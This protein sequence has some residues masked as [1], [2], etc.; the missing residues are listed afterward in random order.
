MLV[1]LSVRR[2]VGAVV[3]LRTGGMRSDSVGTRY[4]NCLCS[5]SWLPE[6]LILRNACLCHGL[7][8]PIRN[9]C[10]GDIRL[11]TRYFNL[12]FGLNGSCIGPSFLRLG[13]FH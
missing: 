10:R 3:T 12:P 6:G 7:G 13:P 2:S 5:A 1:G 4:W 8:T 11:A 9:S